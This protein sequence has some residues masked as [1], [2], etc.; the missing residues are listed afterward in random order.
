MWPRGRQHAPSCL[1]Q[2]NREKLPL[3]SLWQSRVMRRAPRRTSAARDSLCHLTPNTEDCQP[4]LAELPCLC[5]SQQQLVS[6]SLPGRRLALACVPAS[7]PRVVK[8]LRRASKSSA[9]GVWKRRNATIS[10]EGSDAERPVAA[11]QSPVS[12]SVAGAGAEIGR[13]AAVVELLSAVRG[14]A[15]CRW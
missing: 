6:R 11:E 8:I 13:L 15:A 12:P 7:S 10:V 5:C 9:A 14:H 1:L 4:C 3:L 2:H